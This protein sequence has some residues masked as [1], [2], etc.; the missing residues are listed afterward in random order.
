VLRFDSPWLVWPLFAAVMAFFGSLM[1][2]DYQVFAVSTGF[3]LLAAGTGAGLALLV[4]L[5]GARQRHR[6]NAGQLR[7]GLLGVLVFV[8]VILLQRIVPLVDSAVFYS[9]VLGRISQAERRAM[10]SQASSIAG[11]TY[12][13]CSWVALLIYHRSEKRAEHT[14]AASAETA[15]TETL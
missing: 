9:D 8:S 6:P 3:I 7:F 14:S 5:L 13:L 4:W 1:F 10:D 12:V 11:C 2:V 15:T